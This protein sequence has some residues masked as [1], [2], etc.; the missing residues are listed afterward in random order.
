MDK[1]TV[2]DDFIEEMI[3]KNNITSE[4]IVEDTTYL[5][6]LEVCQQCTSLMMDSTCMHCGCLVKYRAKF[7]DKDCPYPAGSKWH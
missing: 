7:S 3:K 1:L 4:Q 5:K 6:R 2:T